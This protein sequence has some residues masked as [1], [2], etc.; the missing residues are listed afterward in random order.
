MAVTI[1]WPSTWRAWPPYF[2]IPLRP[3]MTVDE[4]SY[5]DADGA[6]QIIDPADYVV[7]GVGDV[8]RITLA[9]GASWPALGAYPEPVTIQFTAGYEVVPEPLKQAVLEIAGDMQS[10][11]SGG[12]G[13]LKSRTIEGLGSETYDVGSSSSSRSAAVTPRR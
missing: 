5:L 9:A 11:S 13:D 3:L 4:I 1:R 12:S 10:A 7:S 6:T 2:E 8:G